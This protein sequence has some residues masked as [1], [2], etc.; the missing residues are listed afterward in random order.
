MDKAIR[1]Q[2][3]ATEQQRLALEEFF[4]KHP[5]ANRN[6]IQDLGTSIGLTEKWIQGWRQ[7]K[8]K[9]DQD[10]L[11]ENT[12]EP[13]MPRLT[14][15]SAS[16]D[17]LCVK[18]EYQEPTI[19]P[20]PP[21]PPKK[22]TKKNKKPRKTPAPKTKQT[23]VTVKSETIDAPLPA[24]AA[25]AKPS[26]PNSSPAL[27]ADVASH[28]VDDQTREPR[29]VY[30]HASQLASLAHPS[31]TSA[32][33][34]HPVVNTSLVH[35]TA[36][37]PAEM[38][39]FANHSSFLCK[40][41]ATPDSTYISQR[42]P[43][44]FEPSPFT[45][46]PGAAPP[47][48]S[49]YVTR[50]LPYVNN[51]STRSLSNFHGSADTSLSHNTAIN[52]PTHYRTFEPN[53]ALYSNQQP[54]AFAGTSFLEQNAP[55]NPAQTPVRHL[56]VVAPLFLRGMS[57]ADLMSA[58]TEQLL[59]ERL[60]EQD[61]FQAAMG[62]VFLTNMGLG[63]AGLSR[64]W[65]KYSLHCH[66]SKLV[67]SMAS[68]ASRRFLSSLR[69]TA[70]PTRSNVS[71]RGLR[72]SRRGMSSTTEAA[73]KSSDMPW[74]I[75]SALVFGPATL[76]LLSPSSRKTAPHQQHNDKHEHEEQQHEAAS[77]K[78]KD[79]EGKE[80]DVTESVKAAESED[81]PKAEQPATEKK[82]EKEEESAGDK[83]KVA[84]SPEEA[85]KEE[86]PVPKDP[87]GDKGEPGPTDQSIPKEAST[88]GESPKSVD[89]KVE[90]QK[91]N[92]D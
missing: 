1:R 63:P 24:P 60:V 83:P 73:K 27:V 45:S 34:I 9:R 67:L 33:T 91:K 46:Y 59:D 64:P 54:P 11:R 66:S 49:V 10:N 40:T 57:D 39:D 65:L 89:E 7:R 61:P 75:G 85:Q 29:R 90:G 53:P 88:K 51:P 71:L 62:L 19:P 25:D 77:I 76:Y 23:L 78:M 12:T 21:E 8:R 70:R 56:D 16:S 87:A 26:A 52:I 81:V 47:I 82:E 37:L 32:P 22:K 41:A 50:A 92:Q 2:V 13:R 79:D 6:S 4:E 72:A 48:S 18:S 15:S 80:A 74:I 44:P 30:P 35:R 3:R 17:G 42:L 58:M 20:A 5:D 28:P 36:A 84:A 38:S 86:P 31:T 69:V 55:M 43:M 14:V 68:Q